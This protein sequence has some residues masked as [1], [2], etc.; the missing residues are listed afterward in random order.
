MKK[1]EAFTLLETLIAITI[2]AVSVTILSSLQVRSFLRVL[3]GRESISR[4]FLIKKELY[5]KFFELS[6]IKK[7]I[8]KEFEDL[9]L[10]I[11][12]VLKN[13]EKKSSLNDYV[14]EIQILESTGQWTTDIGPGSLKMFELVL[15]PK[16]EKK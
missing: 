15:R 6:K 16:E 1:K 7:P 10:K 9:N 11:T 8:I 12:T 3:K 5:E 14:D 13:I 4:V 2:L